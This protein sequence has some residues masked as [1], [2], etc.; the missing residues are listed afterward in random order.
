MSPGEVLIS[1]VQLMTE[2]S[3]GVLRAH[4]RVMG[5]IESLA[6]RARELGLT[7]LDL[8]SDADSRP[9]A[10]GAFVRAL[11]A[12]DAT[13]GMEKLEAHGLAP[14]TLRWMERELVLRIAELTSR[15]PVLVIIRDAGMLDEA[16]AA[17]LDSLTARFDAD[18]VLW[19]I[20]GEPDHHKNRS[21]V[22][23]SAVGLQ[24]FS[25]DAAMVLELMSLADAA[26]H[27]EDI[28]AL[29][30]LTADAAT[31][32]LEELGALGVVAELDGAFAFVNP[33][34]R[35]VI[36]ESVPVALRRGTRH[37]WLGALRA[38]GVSPVVLA[39]GAAD[40]ARPGDLELARLLMAAMTLL[41]DDDPDAACICGLAATGIFVDP[42]EELT[43]HA[44]ELLPLL[45]Q[46]SRSEEARNLTRRVFADR[47]DGEVEARVLFWLSRF[48]GSAERSV[49][50]TGDALAIPGI[51]DEI[52]AKLLGVRIRCLST[53]GRRA[54]VDRALPRAIRL[55]EAAEDH[56][57]LSR[58]QS[59]DA[60]RSFY[61]G[62]YARARRLSDVA[63]AS[64]ERSGIEAAEWM[65]ELIWR[66]FLMMVLGDPDSA[67]ERCE[68]LISDF[69][70]HH[71]LSA[72]RFLLAL[73]ATILL[74]IG[75]L[76][77]AQ[78]AALAASAA[79]MRQWGL[80]D[81]ATD[82]LQSMSLAVRLKIALHRGDV[83][84]LKDIHQILI[85]METG[86]S[87]EADRRIAWWL[88]LVADAL[89]GGVR[90]E[91]LSRVAGLAAV[92]WLDPTDELP[93]YRAIRRHGLEAQAVEMVRSAQSRRSANPEE[94]LASA[95]A[96]HLAGL[97]DGDDAALSRAVDG[98]RALRRPLL[99]ASALEDLAMLRSGHERTELLVGAHEIFDHL[100]ALRDA[101]RVRAMLRDA[102]RRVSSESS[103]DQQVL[104]PAE[105][106]VVELAAQGLTT[107]QIAS[108]L[109]LSA[110]T[111]VSHLR[112]VYRK[113]GLRSRREL[114]QWYARAGLNDHSR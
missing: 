101:G 9:F 108:E 27:A 6:D 25:E 99:E 75:D 41:R 80:G 44:W 97:S 91:M 59:S 54:E 85:S 8:T 5:D 110:H 19:L 51:S 7:V 94:S 58:V 30:G 83:G 52:T 31:A 26:P 18:P 38:R 39:E 71:Q 66:P 113:T 29:C 2:G 47:G 11:K 78:D 32:V 79:S 37:G 69:T 102:G 76:D 16:S 12:V 36:R 4:A 35:E 34:L 22:L 10:F 63:H 40:V 13:L 81:G 60:I 84:G 64:F 65:P 111:V 88:F 95:I 23:E 104:S 3:G 74:A 82:R 1:A 21:V 46:T 68:V 103:S 61:A 62:D 45:W 93:I 24:A 105:Q 20:S 109:F 17:S 86:V 106:R 57:T 56:E 98:W 77:Q 72:M 107:G 96:D 73:R 55:A 42:D 87:D 50:L 15:A 43:A 114:I 48:E 14:S 89:P 100:G 33:G 49:Q 53:L 67:R 90:A 28:A 70:P 92:S 112:S